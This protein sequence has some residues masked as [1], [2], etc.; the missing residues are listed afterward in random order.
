I[1]IDIDEIKIE[2]FNLLRPRDTNIA[3]AVSNRTGTV[4][5]NSGGFYSLINTLENDFQVF[6]TKYE[7]NTAPARTL[8]SIIDDSPFHGQQIDLLTVDVESHDTEVLQSLGLDRYRPN[9]VVVEIHVDGFSELVESE[10]FQL[11]QKYDYEVV[12][13]C[14]PSVIF[15]RTD[16]K[17]ANEKRQMLRRKSA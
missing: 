6:Y 11:L 8:Q 2:G 7:K 12:N 5:Y 14:G 16:W 9:V 10:A 17:I 3:C 1:N 13:W 4:E 15:K